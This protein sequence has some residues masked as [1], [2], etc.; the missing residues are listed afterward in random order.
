MN[1]YK[2]KIFALS[3]AGCLLL[4][5]CASG[6]QRLYQWES[7]QPQVYEYFKAQGSGPEEQITVLE[8]DIQ[9]IR[10]QGRTPP[11]GYHAHLGLL[12]SKVGKMD[13]VAQ[14]LETE[15]TLFPESAPYMDFFL[16][17]FKR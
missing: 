5:G 13:Q 7:Y 3:V 8:R 10:S 14:Q 17:K 1:R 6:P 11:P 4:S 15:K 2:E 9:K 16:V 12:Y